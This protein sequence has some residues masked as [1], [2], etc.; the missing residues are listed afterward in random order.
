MWARRRTSVQGR[1]KIS[2]PEEFYRIRNHGCGAALPRQRT[3]D[4]PPSGAPAA[5]RLQLFGE[6]CSG[7]NYLH[8]LIDRNI[9]DLP[10]VFD[11]GFKHAPPQQLHRPHDDC[12]FCVIYRDPFDWIRSLYMHPWHVAPEVRQK[13]FGDFIRSPWHCVWDLDANVPP[14]SPNFGAEML[15]ERH[16]DTGQRYANPLRLR[17]DRLRRWQDLE[18]RVA[19]FWWVQYESLLRYPQLLIR[20]LAA[21]AGRR[22][23]AF[24]QVTTYKGL[25]SSPVYRPQRYPPLDPAD[26]AFIVHQ[27]DWEV[28]TKVGYFVRNNCSTGED[29]G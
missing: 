8:R 13:P 24:Q 23:A 20:D 25:P 10:V 14:G 15:H 7:T 4:R 12:L 1:T 28:E 2:Q 16:P 6:R 3:G 22:A 26:Q 11:F 9:P 21:C 19:R 18:Q 5:A 27:L 29:L 17:S